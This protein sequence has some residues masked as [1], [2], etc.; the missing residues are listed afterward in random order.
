MNKWPWMR[1]KTTVVLEDE[2]M[3]MDEDESVAG[4]KSGTM[5]TTNLLLLLVTLSVEDIDSSLATHS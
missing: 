5:E 3:A 2:Q 4:D 1:M